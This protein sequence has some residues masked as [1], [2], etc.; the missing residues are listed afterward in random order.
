M[1]I[2]LPVPAEIVSRKIQGYGW[3][4]DLPSISDRMFR[5]MA[6]TSLTEID[7]SPGFPDCYDQGQLGSCVGNGSAGLVQYTRRMMGLGPDFIPSR[8]FI[9]WIARALEGTTQEDSGAQIR[10]AITELLKRGVPPETD[11]PYDVAKYNMKPPHLAWADGGL[12][13]IV[14]ASKVPQDLD[15]MKSVIASKHP[16][17]FGF[18]VYPYFESQDMATSGILQMPDPSDQP[19]GGHCTVIVGF[20]DVTQMFRVRNSWGPAWGQNGYFDMPY[21]YATNPNLAS[22]FWAVETDRS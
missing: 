17:V 2:D 18:T 10:D 8:L 3:K 1:A 12:H 4:R 11:W 19:V 20:N 14:G 21:A 16:I 6:P 22:D 9:Y 5:V 7:L 13:T 15:A